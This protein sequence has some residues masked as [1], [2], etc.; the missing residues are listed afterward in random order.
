[1]ENLEIRSE[2][3]E[4]TIDNDP[5]RVIR[6]YPTDVRF[7]EEF[8]SLAGDLEKKREEVA[9]QEKEIMDEKC[10][11]IEK[12]KKIVQLRRETFSIMRNGIDRIFGPGTSQT[13]F[14][15]R[16]NLDMVARFFRG[17]TPFVRRAR[18]AEVDRYMKDYGDVMKC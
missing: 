4:L 1:M 16:D 7:A 13:A 17:V 9:K 12:A 5:G 14:G 18:Q 10:S 2:A 6:F 8:F 15:D 3:V 11:E